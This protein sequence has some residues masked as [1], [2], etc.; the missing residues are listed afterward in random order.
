MVKYVI[1]PTSSCDIFYLLDHPNISDLLMSRLDECIERQTAI[2]TLA[3]LPEAGKSTLTNKLLN[4]NIG[5]DIS[6]PKPSTGVVT[7]TMVVNMKEDITTIPAQYEGNYNKYEWS[8]VNHCESLQ[9]DLGFAKVINEVNK[10]EQQHSSTVNNGIHSSPSALEIHSSAST[11]AV[12]SNSD[13]ARPF[14]MNKESV[15][16]ILN[17]FDITKFSDVKVNGSIY[18]RDVGGQLTFTESLPL[19]IHESSVL[20]FV[21]DACCSIDLNHRILYRS[22]DGKIVENYC[23]VKST[24]TALLQCLASIHSLKLTYQGREEFK[25]CVFIVPTHLD[26]LEVNTGKIDE[27]KT[28]LKK[29]SSNVSKKAK[30]IMD[31][32]LNEDEISFVEK[33]LNNVVFNISIEN[34]L[35]HPCDISTIYNEFHNKPDF[36]KEL[37]DLNK[38]L[39][40]EVSK[41][42]Q[43]NIFNDYFKSKASQVFKYF[44]RYLYP[45]D[46]EITEENFD[47]LFIPK[48][49]FINQ[50][51]TIIEGFSD[52]IE[53]HK[54]EINYD[55]PRTV[56]NLRKKI[57]KL[58]K[59]KYE[60]SHSNFS[61]QIKVSEVLFSLHLATLQDKGVVKLSDLKN[62]ARQHMGI[63]GISSI[64]HKLHSQ[65]GVIQWYD[66][67]YLKE[68]VFTNPTFL[69]NTVTEIIVKTFSEYPIDT[70]SSKSGPQY[71]LFKDVELKNCLAQY[72][73][74]YH[75][76]ISHEDL[77]EF[78]E[79]LRLMVKVKH[80]NETKYFL[81]C[82][83]QQ[84]SDENIQPPERNN[85]LTIF[86]YFECGNVPVGLFGMLIAGLIEHKHFDDQFT[87]RPNLE[88]MSKTEIEFFV[89][90]KLRKMNMNDKMLMRCGASHLEVTLISKR[91]HDHKKYVC[92][93]VRMLLEHIIDKSIRFLRYSYDKVGP[94][95]GVWCSKCENFYSI[96]EY[97]DQGYHCKPKRP[98]PFIKKAL[99][100]IK[101][102]WYSEGKW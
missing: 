16:T 56:D 67:D 34:D 36:Q 94:H 64:L 13:I 11:V 92:T 91:S 57:T 95:F 85:F 24:K 37:Y 52:K 12:T 21:C 51:D 98:N 10:L 27:I 71:G 86:C 84:V 100:K 79:R 58:I 2:L 48:H 18:I 89:S 20:I 72:L 40:I 47:G 25:P 75:D 22:N 87:I 5:E 23:S 41:I 50:I 1:S 4:N 39:F 53:H 3:G 74:Q 93:R 90:W 59:Q 26:I 8:E 14:E 46:F 38:Y 32:L 7:S 83:I 29:I 66:E 49:S 60:T 69:F 88:N 96:M 33:K 68:W 30:S 35:L 42:L 97:A 43:I 55:E 65:V 17:R 61:L 82:A 28:A 54:H 45:F 44:V 63:D 99:K 9:N 101:D 19:L 76:N 62:W 80:Y 102:L 77:L 78:F 15:D 6:R 81:P 70:M 73:Q 31:N